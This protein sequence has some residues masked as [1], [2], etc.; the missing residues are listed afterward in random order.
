MNSS[1]FFYRS[2]FSDNKAFKNK[3]CIYFR[4][5]FWEKGEWKY[6]FRRMRNAI[7]LPTVTKF[8]F[9]FLSRWWKYQIARIVKF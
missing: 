4:I 1:A 6:N 9:I 2:M 3:V 8:I 7:I 5:K